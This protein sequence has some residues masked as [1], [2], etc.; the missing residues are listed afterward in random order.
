MAFEDDSYK[1]CALIVGGMYIKSGVIY[2]RSTEKYDGFS[3]YG[4]I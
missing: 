4:K 1:D 3:D 2:N